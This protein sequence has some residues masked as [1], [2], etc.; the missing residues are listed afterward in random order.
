[1]REIERYTFIIL[2]KQWMLLYVAN[3]FH[4]QVSTERRVFLHEGCLTFNHLYIFLNIRQQQQHI[5]FVDVL[6]NTELEVKSMASTG[7]GA[8]V[9]LHLNKLKCIPFLFCS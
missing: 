6:M 4:K 1:M 8:D 9:L 5:L 7:A 3:V 2:N